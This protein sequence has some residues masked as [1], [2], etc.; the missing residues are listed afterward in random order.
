MES[1]IRLAIVFDGLPAPVVQHPVGPF[2]L[3]LA[4]PSIRLAIEYDGETHRVQERAL[5]D[6]DRQAYLTDAGW[7]VLRFTAAQVMRRPT[8]VAARVREELVKAARRC[9]VV[10]DALDLAGSIPA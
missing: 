10:V 4:Y 7:K 1:R 8:W 3:D 6:L 2:F 9:G 5:R